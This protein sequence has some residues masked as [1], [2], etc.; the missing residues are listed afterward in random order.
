[1]HPWMKRTA[2]SLCLVT[3]LA[4]PAM[5]G[6]STPV[7]D[8]R[9]ISAPDTTAPLN[10]VPSA[11]T[12]N[13]RPVTFDQTPVVVDDVL[14]VPV[15]AIAEA[16]GAEVNWAGEIQMAHVLMPD[17]T[18]LIRL[19]HLE[20][21]MHEDGVTYVDRNRIAMTKMPVLVNGRMLVSADALSTIFGF[22]VQTGKDGTLELTSPSDEPA[23]VEGATDEAEQGTI[24]EIKTGDQPSVL[25]SGAAMANGEARLT[26]VA[27]V[28]ETRIIVQEGDQKRA[29]SISDLQVGAQAAVKYAGPL[30]LS[31]PARGTA[32]EIL[33]QK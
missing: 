28:A 26:W 23:T 5:A 22:Q 32:A 20:A 2:M 30:L 3:A 11:V 16:A 7:T 4:G 31:Y 18:I 24:A 9:L 1:M 27:I 15:R 12:V 14:M 10:Q 17:R 8:V 33:V 21:E 6:E 13:G 19:G 29:G 25:L